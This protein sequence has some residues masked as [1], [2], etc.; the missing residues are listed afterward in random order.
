MTPKLLV[1]L[2]LSA[3]PF[4]A[5]AAP[6][7]FVIGSASAP[8]G[9]STLSVTLT[10]ACLKGD[11]I[12]VAAVEVGDNDTEITAT[13]SRGVNM[14]QAG[15]GV[16]RGAHNRGY[17]LAT[18]SPEEHTNAG[19]SKG[20]VITV[21]YANTTVWKAAIAVCIPSAET[22]AASADN[23]MPSKDVTGNETVV[24]LDPPDHPSTPNEPLFVATII[25]GDTADTWTESAGYKNLLTLQNGNTLNLAYQIIDGKAPT[26]YSA[27]N[28]A[29]R[30][31]SASNRSYKTIPQH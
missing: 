12:Q 2:G 30:E 23:R 16:W 6:Q 29:A 28:S 3:L 19:L 4:S 11:L 5:R 27:A 18:T 1:L 10:A 9:S 24:T 20:A 15:G 14:Y 17:F 22:K 26:R 7:P 13:D 21:T 31:W 8:G 25:E